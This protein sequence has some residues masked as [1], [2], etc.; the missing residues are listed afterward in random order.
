[1]EDGINAGFRA[2]QTV[3]ADFNRGGI[4]KNTVKVGNKVF[5]NKNLVAV[6]TMERRFYGDIF[7]SFTKQ[8][9]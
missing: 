1:M 5:A 8:F 9:L 7:T 6:I 2:N 3:V 4:K